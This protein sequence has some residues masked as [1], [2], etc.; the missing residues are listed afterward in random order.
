MKMEILDFLNPRKRRGMSPRTIE[1][2][3]QVLPWFEDWAE[4]NGVKSV[5]DISRNVVRAYTDYLQTKKAYVG[6]AGQGT[7]GVR[8]NE[9][10][11]KPLSG[12]TVNLLLQSLKTFLR[13]CAEEEYITK[14]PRVDCRCENDW[15]A[16]R[17]GKW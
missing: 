5:E 9:R 11:G 7:V 13:W 16:N 8:R 17:D 2:H 1:W 12:R 10:V 4:N 15:L 3:R 14:A 6:D